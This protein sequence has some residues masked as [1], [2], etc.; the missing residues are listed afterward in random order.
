MREYLVCTI[1]EPLILLLSLMLSPNNEI[2][3]QLICCVPSLLYSQTRHRNWP[4]LIQV[5]TLE[6]L[7][8]I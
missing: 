7:S 3:L 8:L 5:S 1:K 4:Q 2:T 6:E